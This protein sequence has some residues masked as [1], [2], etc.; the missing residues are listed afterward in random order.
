[1]LKNAYHV[2]RP[3]IV[4]DEGHVLAKYQAAEKMVIVDNFI[5]YCGVRIETKIVGHQISLDIGETLS[6]GLATEAAENASNFLD[7]LFNYLMRS[8]TFIVQTNLR[9]RRIGCSILCCQ[10]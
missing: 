5:L 6:L 3:L 4:A 8:H 1:L 10:N 7:V 9:M 2:F